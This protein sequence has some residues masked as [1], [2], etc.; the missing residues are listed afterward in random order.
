[1]ALDR[2]ALAHAGVR[3]AFSGE[4]MEFNRAPALLAAAKI[5][6]EFRRLGLCVAVLYG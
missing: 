1:M 3:G 2:I 5:T 6:F 4:E